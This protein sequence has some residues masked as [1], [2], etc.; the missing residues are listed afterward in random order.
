[1]AFV[2]AVA[3]SF[4]AAILVASGC[5]Y[6]AVYGERRA[7]ERFHVVLVRSVVPDAVATDEVVAGAR[8]QLARDGALADSIED[9]SYP[10]VEIEVLRADE[11]ADGVTGVRRS[12]G[13]G[14][15]PN[16]RAIGRGLVVRG[17][18]MRARGAAPERDTGDLRAAELVAVDR[19][20]EGAAEIDPTAALFHASDAARASARRLGH[21]IA[22][23]ALGFPV[24]Q[25][26]TVGVGR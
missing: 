3:R 1:L 26:E 20:G 22:L 6:R 5:G 9:E 13:V 16:A 19:V 11:W 14:V 12:A 4:F 17:W 24:P 8:E 2:R 21:R 10:R 25:D 23:R 7:S 18:V 15:T